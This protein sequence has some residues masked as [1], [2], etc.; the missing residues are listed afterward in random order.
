MHKVI[1]I[2]NLCMHTPQ[3]QHLESFSWI[4]SLNI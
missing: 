1:I 4:S 2:I 3:I